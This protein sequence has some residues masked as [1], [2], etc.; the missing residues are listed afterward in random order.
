MA[1]LDG[2]VKG[3]NMNERKCG[4]LNLIETKAKSDKQKHT[5]A[6]ANTHRDR[7]TDRHGRSQF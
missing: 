2:H 7:Q 3:C 1:V 5:A 6:L 4:Q